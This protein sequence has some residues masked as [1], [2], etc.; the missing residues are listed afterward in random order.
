MIVVAVSVDQ[1]DNTE[2][3]T[4]GSLECLSG[5]RG[6]IHNCRMMGFIIADEV[7]EIAISAG[8]A[9]VSSSPEPSYVLRALGVDDQLAHSTIRFS[10]GRFTTE[11]EIDLA[12]TV[13]CDA[14]NRLRDMSP[15]WEMHRNGI[16]PRQV[17]WA[18]G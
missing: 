3:V 8:S 7:G 11:A 2:I 18:A 14:V 12:G 4:G 10:V 15:L 5:I 9:C 1:V 6:R 13:V 17:D 16:D